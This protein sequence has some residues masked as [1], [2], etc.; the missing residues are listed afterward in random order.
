MKKAI[1]KSYAKLI[2][3]SGLGLKKGQDVIIK[4]N[5][6]QEDFVSMV[7]KECYNAGAGRVTINWQS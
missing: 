1:L 7:V 4:A 2:V 5:V 3:R 6:D